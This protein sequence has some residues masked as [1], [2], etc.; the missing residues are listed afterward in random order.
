MI[1]I[2]SDDGKSIE[3]SEH[4]KQLTLREGFDKLDQLYPGETREGKRIIEDLKQ[5]FYRT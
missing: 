4:G 3:F 5:R 1:V 2:V